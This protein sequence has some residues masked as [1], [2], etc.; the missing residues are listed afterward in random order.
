[1]DISRI[2]QDYGIEHITDTSGHRHSQ[3]GWVNTKCPFCTG[4]P[5]YHL[6]Y[7]IAQNYFHCW[8]CGGHPV[9]KTLMNVLKV[10]YRQV[11]E[12]QKQYDI[13]V[14]TKQP[15]KKLTLHKFKYPPH[16][17][18]QKRHRL[19][20]EKREFDPDY[21]QQY[22][23][24]KAT[25]PISMLDGNNYKN[26]L[27]VPIEWKGQNV[28]WQTRDV[29]GKAVN[30]YVTCS[31]ER[32]IMHHKHIL[33]GKTEKWKDTGFLVEGVTDVWRLGPLALA[34]FGIKYKPAQLRII[35]KQFKRVFILFDSDPQ[36]VK[37]AEKIKAD[38]RFRNVEAIITPIE[39]DPA[40]MKQQ[41]ANDLIKDLL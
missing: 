40:D 15:I 25:M 2:Y 5:G 28:S 11:R 41:N 9:N 18:L 36:A 35:A 3:A 16:Q 31:K 27:L 29:T 10:D 26:R 34:T 22:W 14:H 39:T 33:Y 7:N 17:E 30:K 1:M 19:Y 32:E 4:N 8:R 37:Q 12:I 21:I 24:V 38:L 23:K 6:G 20:L 13:H